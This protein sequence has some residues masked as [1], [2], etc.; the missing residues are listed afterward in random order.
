MEEKE[1]YDQLLTQKVE[2]LKNAPATETYLVSKVLID[3]IN[4]YVENSDLEMR[5]FHDSIQ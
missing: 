1:L 2:Q 3:L 4:S 5:R